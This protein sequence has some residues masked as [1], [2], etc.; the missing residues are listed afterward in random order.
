MRAL[1]AVVEFN[2]IMFRQEN[3]KNQYDKC[4]TVCIYVIQCSAV[5]GCM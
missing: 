4:F 2:L 1:S 3:I 5:V